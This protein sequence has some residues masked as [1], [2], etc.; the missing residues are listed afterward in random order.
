MISKKNL[1]PAFIILLLGCFIAFLV[2][3]AMR[4]AESGPEV[5]DADY[6]SKGL[7]YTSTLLEKKAAAVLGWQVTTQVENRTLTF[8]LKDKEE[9]PVR[10]AKGILYLFLPTTSATIRLPLTESA[11]GTYSLQLSKEMTGK[12]TARLEFEREGARLNRQLLIN[13]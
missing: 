12:M 11:E 10:A 3:S 5:T 8:L 2:W 13:L 1:Y 9:K 6:Y 4:A 7:R